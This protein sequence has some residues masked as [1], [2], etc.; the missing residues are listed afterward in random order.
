MSLRNWRTFCT[1]LFSISVTSD[2][3]GLILP[4]HYLG[5]GSAFT[6]RSKLW[7]DSRQRAANIRT[8]AAI[9]KEQHFEATSD[10]LLQLASAVEAGKQAERSK[11][12]ADILLTHRQEYSAGD[13]E[14]VQLH[15]FVTDVLMDYVEKF[16]QLFAQRV[17]ELITDLNKAATIL[18]KTASVML[19]AEPLTDEE[20]FYVYGVIHL[21]DV[22]GRFDQVSRLLYLL[23]A[24]MNGETVDIGELGDYSIGTIQ[25]EMNRITANSQIIFVGW[26]GGH[27]RNAM[28]H[29]RVEYDPLRKMMHFTD[30][31]MRS[32]IITYNDWLS[33]ERFTRHVNLTKGVT[34]AFLHVMLILGASDVAFAA[35]WSKQ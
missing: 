35:T 16:R 22:E 30:K 21:M 6:V 14:F 27:L 24:E 29:M 10:K 13:P 19:R 7:Q 34:T 8:R 2:S 17:D 25:K 20:K 18:G 23:C 3:S 12:L 11:T 32:G 5:S 1:S 28:A 31:D 4:P 15:D 26:E 9:L 33:I